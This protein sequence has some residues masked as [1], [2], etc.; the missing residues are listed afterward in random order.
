LKPRLSSVPAEENGLL[1]LY[2]RDASNRQ[3]NLG[4]TGGVAVNDRVCLAAR[5]NLS[6]RCGVVTSV[7]AT[8]PAMGFDNMFEINVDDN[9]GS[10][11]IG[12]SGGIWFSSSLPGLVVGMQSTGLS[13]RSGCSLD[14]PCYD[15]AR[16]SKASD[17][18]SAFASW[19][20]YTP[21]FSGY[22]SRRTVVATYDSALIR[23]PDTAGRDY[24]LGQLSGLSCATN[25]TSFYW[26]LLTSAELKSARPLS[27]SAALDNAKRRVRR[28]YL[29][30]LNRDGDT[31]GVD[32]WAN[33]IVSASNREQMWVDTINFFLT[34]P[35][36][37]TF[38]NSGSY[39]QPKPCL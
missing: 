8:E 28:L 9:N 31:A 34:L 20:L 10:V 19:S 33:Q 21:P 7:T 22:N 11:R 29:T 17:F 12:D 14:D 1:N 16:A 15:R 18:A 36:H 39:G 6:P 13:T 37:L 27:G 5:R 4:G 26:S 25:L 3:Q 32:Y 23:A 30:L 38:R 35:E 24:W 2:W